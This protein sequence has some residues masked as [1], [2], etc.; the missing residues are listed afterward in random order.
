MY[1]SMLRSLNVRGA[2]VTQKWG[3]SGRVTVQH[4]MRHRMSAELTVTFLQNE[5]VCYDCR[6]T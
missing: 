4:V 2:E 6:R 1:A 5:E 3:Y